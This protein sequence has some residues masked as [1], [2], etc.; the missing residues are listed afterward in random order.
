MI[1][2]PL[3][4]YLATITGLALNSTLYYGFIPQGSDVEVS[5]IIN[6]GG[7]PEKSQIDQETLSL[8]V[9]SRAKDLGTAEFNNTVI[10]KLVHGKLQHVDMPIV[11]P[12]TEQYTIRSSLAYSTPAYNGVDD[13]RN[14]LFS[15]NWSVMIRKKAEE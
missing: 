14:H 7:V 5:A 10:Y 15:F 3:A 9:V 6:D 11:S 4:T 8:R 13:K 2:K 1:L 12:D